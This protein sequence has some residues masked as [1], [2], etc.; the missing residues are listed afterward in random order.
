MRWVA[1]GVLVVAC[2]YPNFSLL[3]AGT[4]GIFRGTVVQGPEASGNGWIYLLGRNGKA[5]RVN[6][7]QSQVTYGESVV[8]RDRRE[9][10]SQA[11]VPGAELRVTAEQDEQGNWRAVHVEV[12]KTSTGRDR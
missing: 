9:P 6:V 7:S 1:I 2:A 4:P 12:L 11:V 3:R 5:R 10:A 8:K